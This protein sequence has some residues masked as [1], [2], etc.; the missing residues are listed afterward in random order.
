MIQ[1]TCVGKGHTYI[2]SFPPE[3]ASDAAAMVALHVAERLL[4]RKAGAML[5]TMIGEM[6]DE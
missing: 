6:I 1:L 5:C 4:P 3:D 2:Y